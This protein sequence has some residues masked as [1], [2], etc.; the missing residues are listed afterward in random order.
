MK[1][2]FID[3]LTAGTLRTFAARFLRISSFPRLRLN[4]FYIFP[5]PFPL[6]LSESIQFSLIRVLYH[7][8]LP[9]LL[10]WVALY[11]TSFLTN[12]LFRKSYFLLL[13]LLFK[14]FFTTRQY[15]DTVSWLALPHHPSLINDASLYEQCVVSCCGEVK[16][17]LRL[18]VSSLYYLLLLLFDQLRNLSI[19]IKCTVIII[20]CT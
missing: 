5:T 2:G 7:A 11:E 13:L 16:Q 18:E 8:S 10:L 9:Q 17:E 20:R 4:A 3:Y 1:N 14:Y 6:P 19:G 12:T 15:S